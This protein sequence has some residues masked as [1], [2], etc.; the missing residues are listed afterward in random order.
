MKPPSLFSGNPLIEA[1]GP[2]QTESEIRDRMARTPP[3]PTPEEVSRREL[4][5]HRLNS[6]KEL[7]VV[8][9]DALKIGLTVSIAVREGYR[10][11]HPAD[12]KTTALIRGRPLAGDLPE[13]PMVS[14]VSVSGMGKSRA[15]SRALASQFE[16]IIEHPTYPGVVGTFDQLVYLKVDVPGTGKLIDLARALMIETDRV[17]GTEE[18]NEMLSLRKPAPMAMFNAWL[19]VARRQSLGMLA[20]DEINN[21]FKPEPRKVRLAKVGRA[22]A[23]VLRLV[24]EETLR[25]M[26]TIANTWRIP[27]VFLSTPEGMEAMSSRFAVA[28]RM[29][30]D[31]HHHIRFPHSAEDANTL[32]LYLP[33]LQNYQYLPKPLKIGPAE[34]GE[35]FELTGFVPRILFAAWRLGQRVALEAGSRS[36]TMDHIRLAM[37]T[38]L[39][40]LQA[41][42]AA[43]QSN[44][45][46][47]MRRY[48]DLLPPEGFWNGL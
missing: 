11:R 14:I 31:G 45:P 26:L 16:Q 22:A 24:E 23:P 35:L 33:A 41:P 38:Y 44:D 17:L 10:Y 18:F 48:Q 25:C 15:I 37:Q 1:L 34:A 32:G 8:T 9:V 36:F 6:L 5:M 4:A 47:R 43:L 3:L 27:L 46:M 39:A 19:R 29:C 2:I 30:L 7:N 42:I 40:P 12:P 28:Q 13:T 21:L 20:L